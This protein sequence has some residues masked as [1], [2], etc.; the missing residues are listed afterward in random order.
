MDSCIL[1]TPVARLL[2][3]VPTHEGNAHTENPSSKS[4]PSA[5]RNLLG[6]RIKYILS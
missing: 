6:I 5:F 2:H 1:G 4:V 3:E